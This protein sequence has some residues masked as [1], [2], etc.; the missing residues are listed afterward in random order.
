MEE[1]KRLCGRSRVGRVLV[2]AAVL[3]PLSTVHSQVVRQLTDVKV[4]DI[5]GYAVDDAGTLVVACI[6]SG[7]SPVT[8]IVDRGGSDTHTRSAHRRVACILTSGAGNVNETIA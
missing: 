7:H 3:L 6:V 1:R 4:S 5:R 8:A 2:A